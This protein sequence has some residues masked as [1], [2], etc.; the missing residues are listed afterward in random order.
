M[1]VVRVTRDTGARWNT[2]DF[3]R[4]YMDTYR[5][6]KGDPKYVFPVSAWAMY[7]VHIKRFMKKYKISSQEYKTFLDWVFSEEF[8]CGRKNVGFLCIVN[9]D[10]YQL[11]IRLL[12]RK[13]LSVVQPLTVEDEQHLRERV[14]ASTIL[15]PED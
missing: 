4:F 5:T 13:S 3:T 8:L 6:L 1:V 15:F 14:N 11:F 7:G 12:K 10:V 9:P 2:T